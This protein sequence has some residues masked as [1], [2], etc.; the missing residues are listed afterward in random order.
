MIGVME[1]MPAH[2]NTKTEFF[3]ETTGTNVPKPFVPGVSAPNKSLPGFRLRM[4][5]DLASGEEGLP[6]QL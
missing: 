5:I 3:D 1:P 6:G 4:I 2:D